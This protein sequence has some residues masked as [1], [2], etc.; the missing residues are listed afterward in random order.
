M[1]P[2]QAQ[3]APASC[4][5]SSRPAGFSNTARCCSGAPS[6]SLA[7]SS[8]LSRSQRT[9]M[10]DILKHW[11]PSVAVFAPLV[12]AALMMLIPRAEEQLHKWVALLTSLLV[13]ATTIGIAT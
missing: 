8:S 5:A 10:E 3:R 12:G 7:Y 4:C 2:A 9:P 6:F 13:F 1:A 11:G